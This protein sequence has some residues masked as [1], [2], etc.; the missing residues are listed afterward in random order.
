LP[1]NGIDIDIAL[2]DAYLVSGQVDSAGSRFQTALDHAK[3][4]ISSG[5][6]GDN[7]LHY[8]RAGRA[9]VRLGSARV[10]LDYLNL[11]FFL[12][13][14]MFYLGQIFLALGQTHD[15]LGDRKA[16][17]EDYHM[18]LKYPTA[19]LDRQE[20]EKYLQKAYHN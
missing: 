3:V 4:I 14:R 12:E 6:A 2:G 11:A 10:A 7:A 5:G 20:A 9:A 15:L 1:A 13:E 19:Y 18:V 16:A 17:V 8:L